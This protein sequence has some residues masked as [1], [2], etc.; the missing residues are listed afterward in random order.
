M[1]TLLTST[2]LVAIIATSA[3]ADQTGTTYWTGNTNNLSAG[4][5]FI[6][7]SNG[8]MEYSES[9]NGGVVT[10]VWKTTDAADVKIVVRQDNTRSTPAVT[11]FVQVDPLKEDGSAT[12]GEVFQTDSNGAAVAG[13]VIPAV[14]DYKVSG[15]VSTVDAPTD[16]TT[17]VESSY[18]Q[19]SPRIRGLS[20]VVDIDIQGTATITTSSTQRDLVD[21]NAEYRVRHLITCFNKI[22]GDDIE[23]YTTITAP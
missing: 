18:I 16:W 10:G 19:A 22:A 12:G 9:Q 21:A 7:N 23:D 2:A 15:I 8:T 17:N 3:T 4:C 20:G 13:T 11:Q 1:K 5:Y 6:E 14:V